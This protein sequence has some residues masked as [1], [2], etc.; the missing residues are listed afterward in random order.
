MLLLLYTVKKPKPIL[1]AYTIFFCIVSAGNILFVP[2][3]KVLSIPI[4][5]FAGFLISNGIIAYAAWKE[6]KKM[7]A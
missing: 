1:I 7:P 4:T 3:L 2:Q 5:F 6:Y